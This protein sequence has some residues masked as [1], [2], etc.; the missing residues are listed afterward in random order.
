MTDT[1]HRWPQI[2]LALGGVLWVGWSLV[3][4][5][6]GTPDGAIRAVVG[7]SGLA[8][9]VGLL[10]VVLRLPWTYTF[11]GG[12]GAGIAMLGG[13]VFALGQGL[14]VVIS[15]GGSGIVEGVIGLGVL[16]LVG[17]T[18]LL[19]AGLVRT[20][21]TPPWLGVSLIV[22][23]ILFLGFGDGSG[24]RALL[25]VPLGLAWVAVGGY[26]VRYPEQP[27]GHVEPSVIGR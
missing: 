25:A 7:L 12:E 20:R 14:A 23:T 19:A 13:L 11:P 9:A 2:A 17:G 27:T 4:F 10:G 24:L 5:A 16:A 8:M 1:E 15:A 3:I 26:L 18:L 21:R 22:G 6:T